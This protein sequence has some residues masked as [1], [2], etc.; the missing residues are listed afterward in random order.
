MQQVIAISA[1]HRYGSFQSFFLFAESAPLLFVKQ[2]IP[3]VFLPFLPQLIQFVNLNADFYVAP[4]PVYR[5]IIFIGLSQNGVYLF[6]LVI[7][8]TI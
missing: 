7:K 1:Q 6:F 4:C 3:L 8:G 5:V 2:I